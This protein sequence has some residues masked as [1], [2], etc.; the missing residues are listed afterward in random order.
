VKNPFIDEEIIG[1]DRLNNAL[2]E[3]A[4]N[5][6]GKEARF[7]LDS[8]YQIQDYRMAAHNQTR[9]QSKEQEPWVFHG[10]LTAQLMLLEDQLKIA[11]DKYTNAQP[12]GIAVRHVTGVGPIMA[13]ALMA[14]IDITKA[15]TAG[16]IWSYAGL[17]NEKKWEKGKP[18]P[19]NMKLKVLQYKFGESMVKFQSNP[20]C[21]YGH[22]FTTRKIVE[23]ERNL[24]GDYDL[25]AKSK[26]TAVG[27]STEAWS[28]YN[29]CYPSTRLDISKFLECD[30]KNRDL[31]LEGI[32]LEAGKGTFMLPPAHIH[33]R[34]RRYV[35]RMF[36]S[37]YF[38]ANYWLEY[39]KLAPIPYI[40]EHPKE[41][42]GGHAHYRW[43]RWLDDALPEL[44]AA[45]KKEYPVVYI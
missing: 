33:A 15:P 45:R 44:S 43:A 10:W 9:S 39:K 12:L 6:S 25:A 37:H 5:L 34:A 41:Q 19:F 11:L 26:M 30:M 27:E 3:A 38:E 14:Y 20:K 13:A 18:R 24:R 21:E 8:Y 35:S 23:W 36:L 1:I 32:K 29:G 4:K 7:I 31:M 2:R 16:H 42:S 28:W 17:V 22:L 40:L